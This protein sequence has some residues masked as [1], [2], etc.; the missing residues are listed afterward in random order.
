[1]Q[2][3]ISLF[4]NKFEEVFKRGKILRILKELCRD[5]ICM[6]VRIDI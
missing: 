1:M 2:E 3:L 4:L 6:C 5:K